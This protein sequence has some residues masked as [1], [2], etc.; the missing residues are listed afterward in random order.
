MFLTRLLFVGVV[1]LSPQKSVWA[2][3]YYSR[4][5]VEQHIK[6]LYLSDESAGSFVSTRDELTDFSSFDLPPRI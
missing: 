5:Q 1:L 4:E 2:E 6:T 3:T